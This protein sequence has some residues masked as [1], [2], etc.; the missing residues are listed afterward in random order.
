MSLYYSVCVCVQFFF[1]RLSCAS[2]S[3]PNPGSSLRASL[4]WREKRRSGYTQ[5]CVL[6]NVY[7][8][9]GLPY[10]V[11]QTCRVNSDAALRLTLLFL[12]LPR[13][14]CYL[15]HLFLFLS[16]TRIS[17]EV[18]SPSRIP[19]ARTRVSRLVGAATR[20]HVWCGSTSGQTFAQLTHTHTHPAFNLQGQTHELKIHTGIQ[21]RLVWKPWGSSPASRNYSP[22]TM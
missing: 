11:L 17:A 9:Q 5:T 4:A 2:I 6:G 7:T 19:K 13:G 16:P 10:V 20:K 21:N 1:Q 8:F 14:I 22:A 12:N 3:A 15:P 18:L